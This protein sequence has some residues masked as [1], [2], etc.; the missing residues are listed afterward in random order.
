MA[1]NRARPAQSAGDGRHGSSGHD[2]DPLDRAPKR[3]RDSVHVRTV[4]TCMPESPGSMG[5]VHTVFT[6][7]RYTHSDSVSTGVPAL[8]GERNEPQEDRCG[9]R[10][11]YRPWRRARHGSPCHCPVI[12]RCPAN[13]QWH[14]RHRGGHCGRVRQLR[15]LRP[16]GGHGPGSVGRNFGP[17][18][19]CSFRV[20]NVR[21]RPCRLPRLPVSSNLKRQRRPRRKGC[22]L[23]LRV[24]GR[25]C[26]GSAGCLGRHGVA[27]AVRPCGYR[28]TMPVRSRCQQ[29]QRQLR[30]PARSPSRVAL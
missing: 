1:R 25:W 29:R 19:L 11:R 6:S 9:D 22:S 7:A 20:H 13:L 21:A 3:K 4:R 5:C 2:G 24:T 14:L 23:S 27:V 17:C 15:G 16:C 12:W 8:K 28:P 26:E 18:Q 30:R 10:S